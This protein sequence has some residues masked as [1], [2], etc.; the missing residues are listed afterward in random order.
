MFLNGRVYQFGKSDPPLAAEDFP[1]PFGR[2]WLEDPNYKDGP[3]DLRYRLLDKALSSDGWLTMPEV[4][5]LLSVKE[6]WV[7]ARV[8]SGQ[9]D[10]AM[11]R[12]STIP[13]FR[14]RDRAAIVREAILDR[15]AEPANAPRRK[16]R[17]DK[18]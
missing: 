4:L 16:N 5:R 7:T 11:V 8:R 12:G 14:M 17:W 10:A 18:E 6:P 1:Q 15:P 2:I 9:I 13:L 3:W